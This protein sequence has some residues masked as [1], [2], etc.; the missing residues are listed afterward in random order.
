[1]QR[2]IIYTMWSTH[3]VFEQVEHL[4]YSVGYVVDVG[5]WTR[6]NT[7]T[8][9]VMVEDAIVQRWHA[10]FRTTNEFVAILTATS[11][12]WGS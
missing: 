12:P 1:M 8:P 4:S 6:F 5:V 2:S 11:D 10:T 3:R 7:V 9:N